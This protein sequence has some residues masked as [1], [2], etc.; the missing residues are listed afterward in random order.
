MAFTQEF[1]RH[2]GSID[3]T[4]SLMMPPK[5]KQTIP[6]NIRGALRQNQIRLASL[7]FNHDV[8][9]RPERS[10][11]PP[12]SEILRDNILLNVED[13]VEYSSG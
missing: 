7:Q 12:E 13:E 6:E 1:G 4:I 8:E 10:E 11:R 9:G 5:K 2:T 3:C